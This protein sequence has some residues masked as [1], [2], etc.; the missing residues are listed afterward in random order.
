MKN[1]I[2]IVAGVL[3]LICGLVGFLITLSSDM[4]MAFTLE[5]IS[6]ISMIAGAGALILVGLQKN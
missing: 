1:P 5:K 3:F 2:L 4:D 6:R